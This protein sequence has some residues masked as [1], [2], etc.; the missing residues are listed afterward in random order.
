MF[1][2]VSPRKQVY[3]ILMNRKLLSIISKALL[4]LP[5]EPLHDRDDP[6][7]KP[8]AQLM[9]AISMKLCLYVVPSGM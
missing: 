8:C 6:T 1:V 7:H 9:L 5:D 4:I 2:I 3:T